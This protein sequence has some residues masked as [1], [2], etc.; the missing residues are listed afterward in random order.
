M[1][2]V[3]KVLQCLIS[4]ISSSDNCSIPGDWSKLHNRGGINQSEKGISA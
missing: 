4:K 2:R 1:R 3:I